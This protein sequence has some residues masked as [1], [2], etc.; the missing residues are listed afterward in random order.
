MTGLTSWI[1]IIESLYPEDGWLGMSWLAGYEVV[2]TLEL[3]CWEKVFA[4]S[5]P[6]RRVWFLQRSDMVPDLMS[7]DFKYILLPFDRA[8]GRKYVFPGRI[9]VNL[10]LCSKGFWHFGLRDVVTSFTFNQWGFELCTYTLSVRS[11]SFL[12]IFMED[13]DICG[14]WPKNLTS[15]FT[16]Y[17]SWSRLEVRN[18]SLVVAIFGTRIWTGRK[19][20][21]STLSVFDVTTLVSSATLSTRDWS[22]P[23]KFWD[24]VCKGWSWIS[25]G[26]FVSGSASSLGKSIH[27]ACCFWWK[28]SFEEQLHS[29]DY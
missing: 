1:S 10:T 29:N 17:S 24:A 11:V 15:R 26:T 3:V 2:S 21:M 16:G 27:M 22:K 8:K 5:T 14:F 13:N 23:A 4:Q 12:I 7:L 28:T 19:S 18:N 20:S 25:H 9:S 6:G